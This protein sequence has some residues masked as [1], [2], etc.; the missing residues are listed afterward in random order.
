MK[1]YGPQY[2]NAAGK[3]QNVVRRETGHGGRSGRNWLWRATGVLATVVMVI[4]VGVSLW[5]GYQINSGLDELAIRQ[6]RRGELQELHG[7]LEQERDKL[8]TE[9]RI[10]PAARKMGLYPPAAEQV[11]RM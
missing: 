9:E 4:G 2:Q 1:D 3:R 5:F 10:Q 6:H 7:R 11:K 8:L